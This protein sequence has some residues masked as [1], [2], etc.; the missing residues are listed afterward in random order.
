MVITDR[1]WTLFLWPLE[2]IKRENLMVMITDKLTGKV[3]EIYAQYF[4][5]GKLMADTRNEK[6]EKEIGKELYDCPQCGKH[7]MEE[8]RFAKSYAADDK[9]EPGLLCWV[10]NHMLSGDTLA[11]YMT[12]EDDWRE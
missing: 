1:G 6:I 8:V 3:K 10:C 9:G 2:F 12:E 5:K 7:S 11:D 4:K